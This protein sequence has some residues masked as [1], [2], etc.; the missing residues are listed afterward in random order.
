[1]GRGFDFAWSILE[2]GA[3]VIFEQFVLVSLVVIVKS[4]RIN[5]GIRGNLLEIKSQ[6]LGSSMASFSDSQDW[7]LIYLSCGFRGFFLPIQNSGKRM[8]VLR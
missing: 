4:L 8:L 2:P 3:R 6:V 7:R 1:M 5:I